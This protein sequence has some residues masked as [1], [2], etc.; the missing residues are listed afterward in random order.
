MPIITKEQWFAKFALILAEHHKRHCDGAAC[1]ISLGSI[2]E[3]AE[4]AG[5]VF[6][7]EEKQLFM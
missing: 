2:R 6:T 4:S 7:A 3:M 5:A 1:N